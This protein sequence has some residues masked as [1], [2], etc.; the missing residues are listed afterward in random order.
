ML[1]RSGLG[2]SLIA[3]AIVLSAGRAGA[4]TITYTDS[5]LFHAA[6][7]WEA[8][9][10]DF[11]DFAAGTLL[12]SGASMDGVTVT[13]SIAG[14]TLK[15][16]DAWDTTS[17]SNSLGL[18]GGDE[19]LLDGDVV[20][21]SIAGAGIAALGLFVITSDFAVADEIE[22]VT[23]AGTARNGSHEAILGDGGIVYFVG[24]ISTHTTFQVATLQFANDGETN[25]AY[26]VD[27]VVMAVPEPG[28]FALCAGGLVAVALRSRRARRSPAR[29]EG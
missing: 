4:V 22:L 24:L 18:T 27:D 6:L 13:Y 19:A 16:V 5:A 2:A 8:T 21:A 25:F 17:G 23:A 9:T 11:E 10:L 20:T 15:I 26:N 14:E 12:P 28:T 7:P 3:C 1:R 29:Q